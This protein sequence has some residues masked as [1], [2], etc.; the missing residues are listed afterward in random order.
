MRQ[1][2]KRVGAFPNGRGVGRKALVE[3]GVSG[4]ERRVREV[5]IERPQIYRQR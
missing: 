4:L 3:E 5:R 2:S 1:I